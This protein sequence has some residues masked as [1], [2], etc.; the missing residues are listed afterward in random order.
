MIGIDPPPIL[1][2][3]NGKGKTA[4]TAV[5]ALSGPSL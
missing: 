5:R 3:D 1:R 4:G 2:W